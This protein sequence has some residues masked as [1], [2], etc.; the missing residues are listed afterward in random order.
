MSFSTWAIASLVI[1]SE[2]RAWALPAGSSVSRSMSVRSS[3]SLS[4][5]LGSIS[6]SVSP[7]RFF[8]PSEGSTEGE[9]TSPSTSSTVLSISMAMLIARLSATKVLPSFGMALVT[10]IMFARLIG[11]AERP[12]A[13]SISGRL[14]TRNSLAM[15][16]RGM[17]GVIM[18]ASRRRCRSTVTRLDVF[19]LPARE[20]TRSAAGRPSVFPGLEAGSFEGAVA[21]RP[22]TV[23]P[24]M[25]V[26]AAGVPAAGVAGT[27]AGGTLGAAPGIELGPGAAVSSRLGSAGGRR[28]CGTSMPAFWSWA[29]RWAAS[30]MVLAKM[31]PS[32]LCNPAAGRGDRHRSAEAD[33]QDGGADGESIVLELPAPHGRVAGQHG[34]RSEEW[35]AGELPQRARIVEDRLDLRPAET[36]QDPGHQRGRQHGA[37][38]HRAIRCDRI[39]RDAGRV[40]HAEN[41]RARLLHVAGDHRR[42]APGHQRL[43]VFLLHVVIAVELNEFSFDLRHHA[44][45][46]VEL[47]VLR[48]DVLRPRA[49]GRDLRFGIDQ[50]NFQALV[51]RVAFHRPD[52][53]HLLARGGR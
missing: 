28:P 40:D 27:A 13:L 4:S 21:V 2:V 16:E 11:A 7:L 10:M 50:R 46:S 34:D 32:A 30:S 37:N 20:T 49:R 38:D 17:S 15:R 22:V 53:T 19:P 14:M 3:T 42:L 31:Q 6:R 51:D 23:A 33:D 39:L 26:P 41:G 12:C 35:P 25:A 47:L 43:V 48:F 44:G 45:R 1:S 52:G 18:P 29:S 36:D 24:G 5:R 8:R 9:M